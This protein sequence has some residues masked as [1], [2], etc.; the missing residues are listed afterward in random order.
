MSTTVDQRVVEMRF[1]NKQFEEGIS[2]TMSNLDKFKKSLKLEGATKGLE[3]V[4]TAAN[5]LDFTRIE[6]TACQAGFHIQDVWLKLSNV[7]EYR[8]ARRSLDVAGNMAKALTIEPIMTG[9]SE[10]ETKI[11]AIQ[12]ILSNTASKGTTMEDVTKVIGELNTYADKTIYNFAEMTKNIGTFTAA[13]IGLEESATSIQGIANLAAASGSTS[14]QASTAMYQLSQAL[15]TGTVRLMD[16][17]SVVNAGMG[18]E[19]FQEALK[20]TAREHGVAVDDIIEKNGSFRES[21]Q[22]GWLSAEILSTTLQKFTTGGAKDYA[23]SMVEAGKWT[24]KE[25]DALIAEAQAMEDAATKVKTFT[26]LWD[27]L[28]ESAQSGWSQTWEIIIG[29]FEEAKET[30]T[31]F[32]DVIGGIINASA[33]ARNELL[34]GWKDAGGRLDLVD[35]LFN[36]FEGIMSIVK[37]IK[38]AFDE[39]FPPLTVEQLK[40][41]TGGIKELTEKFKLSETASENLKRTFKGLFAVLDIVGQVFSAIFSAVGSLLGG[42]GELGGG[43]LGV[44]ADIGDALVRFSE[45]IRQSNVLNTVFGGIATVI[46]TVSKGVKIFIS[47]LKEKILSPAWEKLGGVFQ[48]I[49]SVMSRIGDAADGMKTGV[50]NAFG[51]IDSAAEKSPFIKLLQAIWKAVTVIGSAIGKVFGALATGFTNM[52]ANADFSGLLD[53]INT[54]SVG[55]IAVF[56]GKLSKGFTDVV[57]TV[58]SFKDSAIGILDSVRDCF[59]AYQEQLKAG[60]LLKIA[61]AIAILAASLLVLSTIEEDQLMSAITAITVLFGELVGSMSMIS[62]IGSNAGLVKVGAAMIAVSVA[63]LIMASALKKLSGIDSDGMFTGIVGIVVLIEMLAATARVLGREGNTVIKGAGQMVIFAVA[64]KILVSACEDLAALK[65]GELVKGLIG[66]GVLLAGVSLFLNNTSFQGKSLSTAVGIIAISA[67]IKILAS[68][69]SDFGQMSWG[70]ISKGLVAITMLLAELAVF[71]NLTGDATKVISTGI[72]LIAIAAAMKIFASALNDLAALSLEE[73]GRGLF[74]MTGALLAVIAAIYLLPTNL[75]SS[76]VGLIAIATAIL[77]LSNA[78]GSMGGMSWESVAK[79]L[80]SLGGAMLILAV[81]LNAM[82]GTLAGSAAL[83]VAAIAIATLTPS[84]LMLGAMS[85]ES[86]AKGLISIAGAFAVIGVA[87]LVLQPLLPVI[88]GLAGALALIGVGI[89]AAGVG[90][91]AFAVGFQALALAVS[92]GTVAVVAALTSIVS[93]IASLIPLILTKI[94]EGILALCMVIG[95]GGPAICAAITAIL[96]AAIE[97]ITTVL[98]PLMECVGLII[99]ELLALIVSYVPKIVDAGIELIIGLL[100]GI[101]SQLGDIIDAGV[102]LI[103]QFIRGIVMAVPKLVDE[104]M[105]LI[106]DFINGLAESIRTN[107]PL[108]IDATNNLM[109]AVMEAIAAWFKNAVT[110]GGELVSKIGEGIKSGFSKITQ[111]GKDLV[112]GFIDGIKSMISNVASAAKSVGEKALNGIKSFLGIKSPSRAFMEIGE[113]SGEGLINGMLACSK[114]VE[115]ASKSIGSSATKS[116]SK[117]I[118]GIADAFNSDVDAQPTI[119]PVLDLSNIRTGARSISSIFGSG[120]SVE[121]LATAG[122]VNAKMGSINQN[123]TTSDVVSAINK[124]RKDLSN[125]EHSTYNVNGVTYDDGSNISEAVKSIVRAARIERRT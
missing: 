18:G 75:V 120:A 91:T 39:I 72:G 32:S 49:G 95:E 125:M 58:G 69:C 20:A 78:L 84:L 85:W 83:M 48:G 45:F 71:T 117:A 28:K 62:K 101:S 55:G 108:M 10:Y 94:G 1:D 25:A 93:G 111:A 106:I 104:G 123:G 97:A 15:S 31:K 13:G 4:S 23:Q 33:E 76:G 30:L 46:K 14:Q 90:L 100:D 68:A 29:D 5:K 38:E 37:P 52:I 63:V 51:A 121:V 47:I 88:L 61:G 122:S 7:F 26:Q 42:V 65:F 113:Y 53:L 11:G 92:T 2:T 16:W 54:L 98:P 12:T 96:L 107:T 36:I 8:I 70:E 27:T 77:I 118:S 112:Q 44:T 115:N 41:F 19:K 103:V 114:G 74:A 3:D 105:K 66:V 102:N 110:R 60:T 73:I 40:N 22:D 57:E 43:I 87:A 17:N 64:I 109:D 116:M 124:L 34:Q 79:G 50:T 99:T 24:Q 21:L 35:S 89:L 86:I 59:T 80:V 6:N 81:G 82:N 119:R 67:A 56:L 9:F